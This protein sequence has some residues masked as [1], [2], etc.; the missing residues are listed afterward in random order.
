MTS[1]DEPRL[2]Q[3]YAGAGQ[4]SRHTKSFLGHLEDLRKTI[5][6]SAILLAAGMIIAIPLSPLIVELLKVPLEKAGLDPDSFL[7]IIHVTGGFSVAMRIIFWSGLLL[8]APCIVFAIG[9]FVFPGLTRRERRGILNASG[10]AV[11]LF[12]AGVCMGYFL[13]LPVAFRMMF[14]INNWLGVSCEF[15]ELSDYVGFVLKLLIAFGLAFELPVI[16]IALGSMGI[17]S[18]DQLRSK[19]RYVIIGLMVAAML[20]TPPDPLTLLLMAMPLAL[21]YELCIWI[22]RYK[23]RAGR[24]KE[25]GN[26][27]P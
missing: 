22:I 23:E 24:K 25:H 14:R 1:L 6:W 21:L 27:E 16:I 8:S 15:V 5:L 13:T 26:R 10:F 11:V 18:S 4:D 19:R 17:I 12:A 9:W 20:L 3:G 7:K 2:R